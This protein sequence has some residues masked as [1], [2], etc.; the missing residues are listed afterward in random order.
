[1]RGTMYSP[2]LEKKSEF[3]QGTWGSFKLWWSLLLD[4]TRA[5]T[6]EVMF[7][8]APVLLQFVGLYSSCGICGMGL[9]SSCSGDPLFICGGSAPL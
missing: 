3:Q 2:Q 7:S 5:D 6:L 4:C 1:M 9:H 8:L